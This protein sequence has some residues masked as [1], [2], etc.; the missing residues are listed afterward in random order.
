MNWLKNPLTNLS[1]ALLSLSSLMAGCSSKSPDFAKDI[2]PIVFQN[3]S[4]CH[5][6]NGGA[7]FSLLT[8]KDVSKRAKMIAL[9]TGNRY[10]PPWPADRN[11]SHFINERS[12]TDEQI[13]LFKSWY[14]N[15]C[16]MGDTSGLKIPSSAFASTVLGQPDMVID[17]TPVKISNDNRDKFYVLKI[18]CKT[19]GWKPV[20]AVEFIPGRP[21]YAH[22]VNGH[23]LRFDDKTDPFAGNRLVSIESDNYDSEFK[24]LSL[25]NHDGSMPERIHSAFN[26]LPGAF[27]VRYPEGIGGFMMSPNGAFVANDIHYGPSMKNEKNDI[28][29]HYYSFCNGIHEIALQ[30]RD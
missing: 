17:I 23:Y 7:P 9:V 20:R 14:K 26:Y 2:A 18:P 11:Y 24:A 8:Y 19:D 4:P 28:Q 13:S 5:R 10:M 21:E 1:V 15:G 16:P 12:L 6:P 3:C 22:H 29:G 27:G 30:L 25:L